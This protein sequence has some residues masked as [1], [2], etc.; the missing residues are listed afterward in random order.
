MELND[1]E[2][3][4]ER[5]IDALDATVARDFAGIG[6]GGRRDQSDEE[7]DGED[8]GEEDSDPCKQTH[9]LDDF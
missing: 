7:E 3:V 9:G 1:S 6:K 2:A 5:V 4:T 8:E